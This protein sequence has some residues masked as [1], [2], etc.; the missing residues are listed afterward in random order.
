MIYT[1][2]ID[3]FRR[4]LTVSLMSAACDWEYRPIPYFVSVF[5]AQRSRIRVPEPA[6][7]L[8]GMG[9]LALVWSVSAIRLIT[10]CSTDCNEEQVY[11]GVT[12]VVFKPSNPPVTPTP[13]AFLESILTTE[14]DMLFCVPAFIEAWAKN[15]ED[16]EKLKALRLIVSD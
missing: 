15:K 16:I 5:R 14:C 12:L 2:T 10:P 1:N 4:Q 9:V 11:S 13:E 3:S 7:L 8:D 6:L